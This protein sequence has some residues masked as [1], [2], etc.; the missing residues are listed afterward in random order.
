MQQIVVEVVALTI[1]VSGAKEAATR[2]N[3]EQLIAFDND[4]Y[5]KQ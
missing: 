4:T 1:A 2:D 5:Q 3:D